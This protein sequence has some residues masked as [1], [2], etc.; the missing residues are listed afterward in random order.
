MVKKR[1]VNKLI[2][3]VLKGDIPPLLKNKYFLTV[4]AFVVWMIFFDK[5]DVVSQVKLRWHLHEMRSKQKYYS[6]MIKQVEQEKKELFTN[7]AS[8]EKFARERYMMKKDGEDLFVIVPA[9]SEKK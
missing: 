7:S 6:E 2:K 5:N 4:V 8:L 3:K 1:S 9:S